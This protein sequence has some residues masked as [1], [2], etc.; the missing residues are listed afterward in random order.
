MNVTYDGEYKAI[1]LYDSGTRLEVRR[2]LSWYVITDA[3]T[4]VVTKFGPDLSLHKLVDILRTP[5]SQWE[6]MAHNCIR[7]E[8]LDDKIRQLLEECM[9]Y[10]NTIVC[11]FAI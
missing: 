8:I 11:A 2:Q 3:E 10:I 1:I 6:Q 7:L 4:G 5:S 9:E